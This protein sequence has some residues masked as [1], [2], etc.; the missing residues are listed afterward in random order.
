MFSTLKRSIASL[1]LSSRANRRLATQLAS[2]LLGSI[3]KAE[4]HNID[5]FHSNFLDSDAFANAE[6]SLD[7]LNDAII[8][9]L[10]AY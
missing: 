2:S 5:S 7:S 4:Q 3:H 1:D 9:L 10:D 8:S 6:L